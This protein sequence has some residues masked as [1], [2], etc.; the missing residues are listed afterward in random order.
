MIV[1]VDQDATFASR[2]ARWLEQQGYSVVSCTELEELDAM[3]LPETPRG[4]ALD[5]CPHGRPQIGLIRVARLQYP[6]AVLVA[7]TEYPSV[8]LSVEALREGA[9]EV[10]CKPVSPDELRSAISGEQ[11]SVAQLKLPS[12]ARV[13]W[14]YMSRILRSSGGNLSAAARALGV[15]RSTLQR[16]LKKVPP[17][18]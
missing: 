8:S 17:A 7:L 9:D 6:A 3:E 16:K 11:L 4:I 5:V 10:L 12:L 15:Q 14:E 13:E 2:S 18:W 1:L